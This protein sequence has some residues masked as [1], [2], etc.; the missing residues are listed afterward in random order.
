MALRYAVGIDLGTS[1]TAL[2]FAPLDARDPGESVQIFPVPQLLAPGEVRPQLLL[3]SHLYL[4]GP[5]ELLPG[6]LDLPWLSDQRAQHDY[7]VGAFAREQGAR[8]PGRHVS[9]AKSWL[10]HPAVDRTAKILPWGAPPEVVR[11]SPVTASA[12]LL[13]HL[14]EAWD[15][16]HPE[17]R[18]A[19]QDLVVTVPASFDEG[20]RALTLRAAAEAG[21]PRLILLEEPQAAFY[22]WTRVHRERL[23]QELLGISLVLVVDVGGG[24]TD[25]TLIE[26]R[27]VPGTAPELRRLAVGDHLLLGGDNMDLAIARHAESRLGVKLGAGQWGSLVQSCR[28]AKELLLAPEAPEQTKVTVAGQGSRLIGG[29]LSVEL[30]RAEVRALLLDGFFPRASANELPA[31]AARSAGLAEL[32]L[33]Y[34][35]DP[36]I[37]RHAAGFLQRHARTVREAI[38]NQPVDAVLYNGGALAAQLLADRL[39]E[40]VQSWGGKPLA[41][42]RNDAPDLAVARGAATYALVRRGLGLRIGGGS[43]RSYYVGVQSGELPQALCVV[44]RGAPEGEEREIPGRSFSLLLGKPVR[45]RLLAASAFRPDQPG[46]LVALDE[47]LAE[48]PPL[49]TVVQGAG[50]AQVKLRA[51]LTE[52]GTLE[53]SC[54]TIANPGD[55]GLPARWKL[56]FS[57]RPKEGDEGS[58]GPVSALPK[59][60]EAARET[61]QLVFGKK[62]QAV[63][64]REVKDLWRNLER[65]LG[66]RALWT[67]A[68]NRDLWGVLWAG[69]AKRRRS[70]DHERIFLSL[71]GFMLRPGFGAPLDGWRVEQTFSL[72]AQGLTHHKEASVWAA[73]WILWRR[74]AAGLGEAAQGALFEAIAPHLRPAPKGRVANPG[75]RPPGLAPDEMVRLLGALELLPPAQKIEAGSWL[76]ERI[77]A[78]PASPVGVAWALGRLGAR[79]PMSRAAQSVVPPQV[80]AGWLERLLAL[81]FRAGDDAP[82]AIAQLARLSGDRSRDL[83]EA[84]RGRAA[85]RLEQI[86][87][88]PEWALGIRELRVLE[89]RDEQRV[90]GEALPLGLSLGAA[91]PGHER[92]PELRPEL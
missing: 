24:T 70:G 31:R 75:K 41:R 11:I 49:Q 7:A 90:F 33:P 15:A 87:A 88:P 65:A 39:T 26:T 35:A 56:E 73:W 34:A 20:A 19:E 46:D 82:F 44:Q 42:L 77:S 13:L 55:A 79:V 1:N 38:G 25:L 76:L 68:V 86:G 4:A 92:G 91:P 14:R 84:L 37:T 78:S 50:A 18:L 61:L 5:H 28:A 3:P 85:L 29:A 58:E 47:E 71:C 9:S 51:G 48:L 16:A 17:A 80:A 67:L 53:L 45:F 21:L 2:A 8:V 89:Q 6:A 12:R 43:P 10:C 36:A 64:G 23:E 62:S 60:I 72:F 81:D 22:D 54:E 69:A 30:G 59:T 40:V 52:I 74:V 66:D 63:Q 57:L 83:D 32:G 27:L